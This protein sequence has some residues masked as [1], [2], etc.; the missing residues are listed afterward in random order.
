MIYSTVGSLKLLF[1]IDKIDK[2]V[3]WVEWFLHLWQLDYD[4][5]LY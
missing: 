3:G 2:Q 4:L 5:T 1:K